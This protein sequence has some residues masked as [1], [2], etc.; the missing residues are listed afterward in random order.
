MISHEVGHH[1]QHLLW[2]LERAQQARSI[3]EQAGNEA[4]IQLE[5]QADCFAGIWSKYVDNQWVFEKNEVFEAIDAAAAVGDDSI[6]ERTTWTVRP[7]TW[8][9]GSSAQREFWFTRGFET[10]SVE[11]CDTFSA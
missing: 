6:Q 11:E 7:E 5:L 8:T 10:G 4:S 2:T 9:H 3:S 1:V